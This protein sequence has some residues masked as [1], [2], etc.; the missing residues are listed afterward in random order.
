MK[1]NEFQWNLR[2][3]RVWIGILAEI[4]EFYEIQLIYMKSYEFHGLNWNMG[5]NKWIL[6]NSMN[7][8]EILGI[9]GLE[10]EYGRK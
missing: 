6:W 9:P 1:F 10:L 7:F 2:N 3:S 8:N 4:N 5:G